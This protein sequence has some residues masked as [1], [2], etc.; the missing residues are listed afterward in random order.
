MVDHDDLIHQLASDAPAVSRPLPI[1]PRALVWAAVA[2]AAGFAATRL[3][4]TAV[5]DGSTL[6]GGVFVANAAVSLLVGV[7]ALASAFRMSIPGR[8]RQGLAWMVA[9]VLLWAAV[10]AASLWL[11]GNPVGHVGDGR[12]CF[13]F[14]VVAGAPM[15]VVTLLALRRTRSLRPV[16]TLAMA[17]AAIGFLAFGLLA[18][19]HPAGMTVI[20]FAMHLVAGIVLGLVTIVA[21]RW[22]V[23]A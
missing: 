7:L 3:I 1:A 8:P 15:I 20:D 17:G 23:S 13:R 2:V 19:C 21:G 10:N 5:T 18:F 22:L 11:S 9:L 6:V 14:V 4:R 16:P 12:Y